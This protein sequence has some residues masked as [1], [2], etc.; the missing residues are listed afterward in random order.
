MI[1]LLDIYE[2][3]KPRMV[4]AKCSYYLKATACQPDKQNIT[5]YV[6]RILK[7]ICFFCFVLETRMVVRLDQS[8]VGPLL[9]H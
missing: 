9:L 4:S 6:F 8:V 2:E 3:T 5:D 1:L 7:S